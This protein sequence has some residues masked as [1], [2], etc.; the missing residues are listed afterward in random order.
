MAPFEDDAT[1]RLNSCLPFSR[2]C[3]Q[4]FLA[5]MPLQEF[6]VHFKTGKNF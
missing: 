4:D 2:P 5:F 6:I 3:S 1:A